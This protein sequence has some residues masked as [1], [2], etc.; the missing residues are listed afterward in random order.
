MATRTRKAAGKRAPESESAEV[1]VQTVTPTVVLPTDAEAWI[2]MIDAG[3][4]PDLQ[5]SELTPAARES[6]GEAMRLSR[7]ALAQAGVRHTERAGVALYL[8]LSGVRDAEGAKNVRAQWSEDTGLSA[9]RGSQLLLATRVRLELPELVRPDDAPATDKR[10]SF[11]EIDKAI[12]KNAKSIRAALTGTFKTDK[13]QE[14]AVAKAVRAG[15]KA[16]RDRRKPQAPAAPV[17]EDAF[18]AAELLKRV[19]TSLEAARQF[20]DQISPAEHNKVFASVRLYVAAV[21]KAYPDE[22]PESLG[23]VPTIRKA[24]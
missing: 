3:Q 5:G 12:G 22:F 13:Q 10:L 9:G 7:D 21:V 11:S 16:D 23:S 8:A 19:R 1:V 14:T 18:D 20:A 2:G 17:D 24:S 15:I 4:I 6:L